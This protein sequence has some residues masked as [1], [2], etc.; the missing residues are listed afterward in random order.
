M[1]LPT[2]PWSSWRFGKC[3]NPSRRQ[4]IATS[5]GWHVVDSVRVVGFDNERG[6]GDH[7]HVNRRETPYRF[8]SV[9]QL[10]DDFFAEIEKWKP[11]H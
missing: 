11:G 8:T 3:R 2:D 5:T 9:D 6:K 4:I 10:L 1:C 7:K